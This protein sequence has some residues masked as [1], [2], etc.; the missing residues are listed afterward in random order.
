MISSATMSSSPTA[1]LAKPSHATPRLT[2]EDMRCGV[3]AYR[4]AYKEICSGPPMLA[5]QHLLGVRTLVGFVDLEP[6]MTT[7]IG[8]HWRLRPHELDEHRF[9]VARVTLLT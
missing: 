1:V 2:C 4:A 5:C 6:P 9:H 7:D 8:D 3:I